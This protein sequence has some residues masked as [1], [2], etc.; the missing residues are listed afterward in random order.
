M[1]ETVH[2][3]K[4]AR[5][6]EGQ[7]RHHPWAPSLAGCKKSAAIVLLLVAQP[8]TLPHEPPSPRAWKCPGMPVAEHTLVMYL[9]G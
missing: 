6:K 2:L 9:I 8:L 3:K 4:R 5:L 7:P 1:P